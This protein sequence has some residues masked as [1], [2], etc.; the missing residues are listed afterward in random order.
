MGILTKEGKFIELNEKYMD[1]NN[2]YILEILE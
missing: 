1:E 2:G